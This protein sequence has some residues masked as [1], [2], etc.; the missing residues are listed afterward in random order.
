MVLYIKGV[1][2]PSSIDTSKF[3]VQGIGT[4]QS[5]QPST[6]APAAPAIVIPSAPA[7]PA[8]TPAPAPAPD[9]GGGGGGYSGL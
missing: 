6:F 9:G 5:T 4:V 8:P 2:N 7:S 1:N 3:N